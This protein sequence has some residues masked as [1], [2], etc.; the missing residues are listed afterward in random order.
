MNFERYLGIIHPLVHRV[1]LTK[2]KLLSSVF[3]ACAV[4]T[5]ALPMFFNT[6]HI[7]K[8]LTGTCM[9]LFLTA[10]TYIYI[11]IFLAAKKSHSL[12]KPPNAIADKESTAKEKKSNLREIKLAKSCL[13]MV[14]LFVFSFLPLSTV[15]ILTALSSQQLGPVKLR[16]VQAWCVTIVML[17]SSLNSVIF[18]WTRSVLQKEAKKIFGKMCFK[19]SIH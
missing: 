2:K 12:P 5:A 8:L 7:R 14:L 13:M 9:L 4:Y 3:S 11:R 17:N 15:N 19:H 10:S 18:F 16:T 1:K 6:V